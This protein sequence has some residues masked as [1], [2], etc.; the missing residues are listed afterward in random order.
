MS[1]MSM[2]EAIRSATAED[3][4]AAEASPFMTALL[5]GELPRERY[6]VFM[7]QLRSVYDELERVA[8]G[9]RDHPLVGAFYFPE[10][11]RTAAIEHDLRVLLGDE[12]SVQVELLPAT[13]AY[14]ERI[15]ASAS[16]P[17]A[18]VAHHYT[19]YLGDLSGGFFIGRVVEKTYGLADGAGS[20]FYHFAGVQPRPFKDRYR[21]L[22][23][24]T[25]WTDEQRAELIEEIH[26]AYTCNRDLF[27]ELG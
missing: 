6:A 20:S 16:S 11:E 24:E 7:G 21:E 26:V 17:A 1:V 19:R 13:L 5:E 14:C 12:A 3:H 15:R 2:S 4:S 9:Y 18:F 10:L 8:R 27:A 22:L 23:D 25:P